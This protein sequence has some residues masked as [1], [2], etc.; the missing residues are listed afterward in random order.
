MDLRN[1]IDYTNV[2][3]MGVSEE[4]REKEAE[5]LFK[6]TV[7]ENFHNLEEET[8]SRSRKPIDFQL[9]GIQRACIKTH[10]N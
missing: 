1:T 7:A 2:F 4:E 9:K 10:Y 5:S 6:E 3:V 8:Q